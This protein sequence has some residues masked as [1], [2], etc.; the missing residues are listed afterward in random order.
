MSKY[1]VGEDGKTPYERLKGKPFTR[2]TVEFGEKIHYKK[3]AKG[4]KENKLDPKW[5]EGYFLGFN[6]RTSEAIVGTKD[7]VVKS[8]TI[9]RVGAHRRWDAEGLGEI[10]GV[11]W[12]W[13][14]ESDTEAERLLVR[15]LTDQEKTSLQIPTASDGSRTV[16]RMRLKRDDFIEH[17]FM[18]GCDGC[19]AILSGRGT[20]GHNEKCRRRMEGIIEQTTEGQERVKRQKERENEHLSKQLEAHFEQ[21]SRKK[22]KRAPEVGPEGGSAGAAVRTGLDAGP[23]SGGVTRA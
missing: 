9:R 23:T 1:Q 3:H 18:D 10:R 17:G 7:K 22:Q 20:R 21:D 8:S 13:D 15:H 6:W 19:K 14:P 16:Y 5:D 2:A 12:L 4:Q 11:P